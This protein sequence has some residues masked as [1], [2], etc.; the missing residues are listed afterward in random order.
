MCRLAVVPR[1]PVRFTFE[2]DLK[3]YRQNAIEITNPVRRKIFLLFSRFAL[4]DFLSSMIDG[5]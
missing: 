5:V 2:V 4:G 3:P 1:V